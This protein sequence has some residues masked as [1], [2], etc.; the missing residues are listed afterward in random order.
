MAL[1]NITVED[2]KRGELI[3]PAWYPFE[4]VGVTEKKAGKDAKHPD[5]LLTVVKCRGLEGKAKDHAVY[6]QFSEVAPGF[7]VP[8]ARVMGWKLDG[9]KE[10]KVELTEKNIKGKRF[11]GLIGHEVYGGVSK[12][13]FADYRPMPV[14]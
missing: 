5:S 3:E 2:Q 10:E 8:F 9:S 13:V 7:V 12:N 4:V 6:V 1:F 11:L 14:K